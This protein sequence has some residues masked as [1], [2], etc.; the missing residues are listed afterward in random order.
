MSGA[1]TSAV[2]PRALEA[3]VR[4][5][6][7]EA[8]LAW[9]TRQ[10]EAAEHDASGRH[11][12]AAALWDEGLRLARATY[13]GNDPRLAAS[14]ANQAQA[15]RRAG[16]DEA[17]RALFEE[18][19][20]AWD[21]SG[22]W[23]AALAPERR[24]RSSTFHLRLEAKHPGGYARHSRERYQALAAEGRTALL[25]LRDGREG[26]DDRL[27]RWHRERPEGYTDARKLLAAVCL[28]APDLER[29]A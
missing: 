16:R 20:L 11:D 23:V 2:D 22:A 19:L 7:S 28:I 5:G 9:E 14:L 29:R 27:A 25:A 10:A 6:W 17:A 8:D 21:A 26:D 12:E 1:P 13:A 24:A 3:H 15:L 18:A 4:A